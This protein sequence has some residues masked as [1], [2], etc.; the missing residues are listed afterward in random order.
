MKQPW[1]KEIQVCANKVPGVINGPIP[2]KA[3][4]W[5]IFL[6]SSDE[7]VDHIVVISHCRYNWVIFDV[8]S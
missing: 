5:E 4:K 3:P 6:K 8:L 2:R 1:D 7:L